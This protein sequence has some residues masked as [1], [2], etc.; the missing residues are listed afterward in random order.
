[1]GWQLQRWQR[2]CSAQPSYFSLGNRRVRRGVLHLAVTTCEANVEMALTLLQ[3]HHLMI[4]LANSVF[5]LGIL[6]T[7][8]QNEL[9][10]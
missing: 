1:V 8:A 6:R 3:F 2:L 4:L 10:F 9:R 7:L 5:T